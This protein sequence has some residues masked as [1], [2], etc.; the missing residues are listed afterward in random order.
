MNSEVAALVPG[1]IKDPLGVIIHC[2]NAPY[3]RI[4]SLHRSYDPLHYILLF[5]EGTDGW[6][7]NSKKTNGQTLTAMDFYAYHLEVRINSDNHVMRGRL[8]LDP[9]GESWTLELARDVMYQNNVNQLNPS[10]ENEVLIRL[11]G[12]LQRDELDQTKSIRIPSWLCSR[13]VIASTNDVINSVNEHR[14][15]SFPGESREYL[16]SDT[17]DDEN[18]HQYPQNFVNNFNPSGL[19]VHKI[20]LKKSDPSNGHCNGTRYTVTEL[21]SHVIEAVIATGPS[22]TGKRLFIPRIPLMPSDN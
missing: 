21:N 22:Y 14:I 5:Q 19:P 1:D 16:S 10:I 15:K 20:T 6:R 7:L 9:F 8:I 3:K 13:A 4:N 17:V 18:C 2:Q 11:Q 12:R